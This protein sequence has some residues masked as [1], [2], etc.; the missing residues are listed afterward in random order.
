MR[1]TNT[2]I[3]VGGPA[4][5]G[6]TTIAQK[7]ADHYRCVFIEGDSY[8]PKLNIEKMSNGIPLSDEDRWDWLKTLAVKSLDMA[9]HADNASGISVVS[10]SVLKRSYR[11][12]IS[13]CAQA[14]HDGSLQIRYIFLYTSYQELVQRVTNRSGHFMKSDMVKSQYDI[15]EIPKDDELLD[16]GGNAI[17]INSAST[18]AKEVFQFIIDRINI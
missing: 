9:V 12:Y 5:T 3:V 6:K 18:S 17:S 15:M 1:R 7:L 11:D 10:C 8:H 2:I 4:G 16:N 13:E 14:A